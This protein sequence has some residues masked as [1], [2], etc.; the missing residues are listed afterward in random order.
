MSA[1]GAALGHSAAVTIE[2]K[3]T[4]VVRQSAVV[5]RVVSSGDFPAI[6]ALLNIASLVEYLEELGVA[7]DN[8][9]PERGL[10]VYRSKAEFGSLAEH[11]KRGGVEY[12]FHPKGTKFRLGEQ[13]ELDPKGKLG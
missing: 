1:N 11:M 12:W 5:E 2:K 9:R 13:F 10:M 3:E 7:V 8:Q 6:P 4:A